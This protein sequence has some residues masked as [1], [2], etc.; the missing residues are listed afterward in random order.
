M[1]LSLLPPCLLHHSADQTGIQTIANSYGEHA[2]PDP[3]DSAARL[4][5]L[6]GGL[7]NLARLR[8]VGK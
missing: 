3:G 1:L 2:A 8:W 7:P 4:S 6:L 5:A